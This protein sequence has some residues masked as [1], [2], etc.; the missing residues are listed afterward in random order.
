MEILR[1]EDAGKSAP[2][3][4]KSARG[5]IIVGLVATL[6]GVG[7]AFASTT[8]QI[9]SGAAVD[10]GQGVTQVSACDDKIGISV[11]LSNSVDSVTHKTTNGK[12]K[13]TTK[14]I[15]FTD[16]NQK[17]FD[18]QTALGCG[19]ETFDLQIFHPDGNSL[20]YSVYQ[21]GELGLKPSSVGKNDLTGDDGLTLVSSDAVTCQNNGTI[22]IVV[23]T[24]N[25]T[26]GAFSIPIGKV[27][28]DT[29]VDLLDLSYFTLVS[30]PTP[31][32]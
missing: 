21:C 17:L 23:P 19:G 10:V 24:L 14:T 16:V 29:K 6:F 8:I 31:S 18:T 20:N 13:F 28:G 27:A 7:T 12:P 2:N 11:G 15:N 30:R 22:S 4:K 9:N 1:F 5:M 32:S 26:T 25:T 3:R